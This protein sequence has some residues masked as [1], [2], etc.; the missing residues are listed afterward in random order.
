M[1]LLPSVSG[2]FPETATGAGEP[3]DAVL[4]R[5]LALD[6]VRVT[7]AAALGAASSVGRGDKNAVDGAAVSAMRAM[8]G[9]VR[10]RGVVVIGEGEKDA[11]PMLFN[12][13]HV[14]AGIGPECD[15][16]VDPI[17]G[18]TLASKNLDNALSVIALSER[19][20]MYDPSAVFYMDKIAAAADLR[21][22]LDLRQGATANIVAL[23]RARH[24]PVHDVTVAVLERPRH[25]ELV[26]EIR[27]TGARVKLIQDGDV[28][29]AILAAAPG[30]GIDLLLG[31]GGTPEGILAACALKCMG[32]FMQGRLAP[33]DDAERHR[34]IDAG[35]DVDRVLEIS[36]L[37]TG[38]D[39][40]FAASGVT[41]GDLLAGV[42]PC[43]G[44]AVVSSL[45]A[46][47][48]S[49]TVRFLDSW[50]LARDASASCAAAPDL[51]MQRRPSNPT[52]SLL[53]MQ[54]P[55]LAGETT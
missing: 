25:Q 43:G 34:A 32:G 24:R 18:T 2:Q 8:I 20:S 35:H 33:R 1:Q 37:V 50:Y 31:S 7:E 22:V 17:D 55:P 53:S 41:D 3:P 36:D 15:V 13:E 29:G 10:M 51:T 49:G 40:F 30:T 12:G 11:A 26:A 4:D 44:H 5:N 54:Q 47:S 23:A 6:L 46:R 16:A 28:A 14:G 21:D 27:G 52:A 48:R 38:D 9:T 45:V 42:R 39:V 19:G